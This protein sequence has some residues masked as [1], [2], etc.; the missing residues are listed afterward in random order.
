MA[1]PHDVEAVVAP[2]WSVS[3]SELGLNVG[4]RRPVVD[5]RSMHHVERPCCDDDRLGR[6][7]GWRSFELISTLSVSD[8]RLCVSGRAGHAARQ[9][10]TRLKPRPYRLV[11]P[12]QLNSTSEKRRFTRLK[13]PRDLIKLEDR[14]RLLLQPP[15]E[16]LLAAES[17]R[18]AARPFAY[19]LDGIAFLY[20]RYQAVL[21]DEMGLGKTMQAITAIRLLDA[22]RTFAARAVGVPQTARD[23]LAA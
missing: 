8:G 1:K 9:A 11:R 17:L 13:P 23:Q 22:S 18:F 14:L 15:L 19:Q 7:D 3:T 16:S 10:A 4:L 2:L 21:A 12:I 6:A 20:P 5:D